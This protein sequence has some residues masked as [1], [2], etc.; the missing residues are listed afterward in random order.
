MTFQMLSY[1]ISVAESRSFTKAAEQCFVTQ[2]ALSRAIRELEEELGC[3]LFKRTKRQVVLTPEGEI[4]LEE[5]RDILSR[6]VKMDVRLRSAHRPE[7]VPIRMG[8]IIY[9]QMENLLKCKAELFQS[10]SITLDPFYAAPDLVLSRLTYGMIDMAVMDDRYI[11]MMEGL[12]TAVVATG[13]LHAIL[14]S[15]HGF[16]SRDFIDPAELAQENLVLWDPIELRPVYQ[17]AYKVCLK[18]GFS[19]NVVATAK[20]LGDMVTQVVTNS[21]I[22]LSGWYCDRLNT[23]SFRSVPLSGTEGVM[24][25]VLIWRKDTRNPSVKR[26]TENL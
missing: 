16:C 4:C 19:P 10:L 15:T 1:F 8:Y 3:Q 18:A 14:P 22:G 17:A 2:P 9:H 7:R 25:L 20:K 13:S 24:H 11:E 12:S 6:A 26:L 5:A 23:K 21:A